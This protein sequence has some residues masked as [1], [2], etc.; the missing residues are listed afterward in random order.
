MGNYFQEIFNYQLNID[1]TTYKGLGVEKSD[2]NGAHDGKLVN[3][4]LTKDLV[5]NKKV[6]NIHINNVFEKNF[7]TDY[8]IPFIGELSEFCYEKKGIFQ[9]ALLIKTIL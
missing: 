9:S 7:V 4:P 6:Y 1:P 5:Q 2:D 8:R 3:L